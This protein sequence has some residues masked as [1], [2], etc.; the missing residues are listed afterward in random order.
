[1][2]CLFCWLCLLSITAQKIAHVQVL[3]LVTALRTACW[4]R[5]TQSCIIWCIELDGGFYKLPYHRTKQQ[6][7]SASSWCYNFKSL[8]IRLLCLWVRSVVEAF[9][10][11]GDTSWTIQLMWWFAASVVLFQ[12]GSRS[13]TNFHSLISHPNTPPIPN[14]HLVQL[15]LVFLFLYWMSQIS[16]KFLY[17]SNIIMYSLARIREH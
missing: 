5:C 8:M 7:K 3:L 16:S 10:A 11:K 6:P 13:K 1:M 17:W 4:P 12:H 2:L 15:P 14:V 9:L